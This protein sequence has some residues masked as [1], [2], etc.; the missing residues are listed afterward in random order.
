MTGIAFVATILFVVF[1]LALSAF[2]RMVENVRRL[3]EDFER[4]A[5]VSRAEVRRIREALESM[6]PPPDR[7]PA[8]VPERLPPAS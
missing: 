5:Q 8:L 7:A 6:S 2:S 3:L 1:L 4:E